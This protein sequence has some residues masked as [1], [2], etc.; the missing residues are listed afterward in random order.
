M[1]KPGPSATPTR[2][3]P[4]ST[5]LTLL[6]LLTLAATGCSSTRPLHGGKAATTRTPFAQ[7]LPLVLRR[8]LPRPH[9]HNTAR[10]CAR[11]QDQQNAPSPLHALTISL[12]TRH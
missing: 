9:H 7:L 8:P 4:V 10:D 1:K 2:R 12:T 11:H 6:T 3:L 5:A